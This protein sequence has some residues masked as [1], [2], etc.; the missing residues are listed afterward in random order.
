MTKDERVRRVALLCCHFTRNLAYFR[1][2][3]KELP[4]RKEGD[5]WITVVGNFIDV[6]V[7]EWSK[8]FVDHSD[9][10]HWKQIV[11]DKKEFKS[12]LIETLGITDAD[13][14]KSR[15]GIKDYRDKFIAHLDSELTMNVPDMKLPQRMV[16]FYFDEIRTC[17]SS[18]SVLDG[19]PHDMSQYYT[20]CD[21]E[22]L[23]V[24][25]HNKALQSTT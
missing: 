10:H 17:C 3:W 9:K 21:N 24:Y 11:S 6:S 12:R 22:A 23:V 20:D 2:G 7:L 15:Q 8:L 19:M 5:F 13:W 4:L 14:S 16:E 1:A 18:D 25:K